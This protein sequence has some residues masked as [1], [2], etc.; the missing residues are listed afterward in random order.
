MC[1]IPPP[2]PPFGTCATLD[3]K[4]QCIVPP[5]FFLN[6]GSAPVSNMSNQHGCPF[7]S[8]VSLSVLCYMSFCSISLLSLL[9]DPI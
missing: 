3:A 6:P 2:P 7:Q 1:R 9:F 5:P 8:P 4:K